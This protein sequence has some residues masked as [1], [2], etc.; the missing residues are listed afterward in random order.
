MVYGVVFEVGLFSD[1]ISGGIQH[2]SCGAQPHVLHGVDDPLVYFVREFVEINVVDGLFAFD[3]AEDVDG[4]AGEH[5]GELDILAAFTDGEAHLVGIEEDVGLFEFFVDLN[6]V[7]VCRIEGTLDEQHRVGRVGNDV[8]VLVAQFANDA[9]DT[10]SAHTYARTDGINVGVEAFDGDFGAFARNASHST[11]LDD[12]FC[13][14]GDLAFE[15]ATQE[16]GAG[17]RKIDL[18]IAV[19]VVDAVDH[20][21]DVV[22][23]VVVVARNLLAFG[24]QEVVFLFVYEERFVLPR[25]VNFGRHHLALTIL[26]LIIYGVVFELKDLAGQGLAE[27]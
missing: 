24:Q 11:E 8:D 9:V 15:Q 4:I 3:F 27:G 26:I 17:A 13:D 7:D 5:G 16:H 20:G 6:V 2:F 10:A 14:F 18:R 22:A 12:A 23:L 21:A 25:L 1:H 19:R